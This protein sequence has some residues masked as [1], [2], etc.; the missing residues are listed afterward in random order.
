VVTL[1]RLENG[2]QTPRLKTLKPVAHALGI[3]APELLTEPELLTL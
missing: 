3:D 1:V 2:G